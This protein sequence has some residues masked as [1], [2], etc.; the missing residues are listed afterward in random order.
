MLII[1]QT[2]HTVFYDVFKEGYLD[3]YKNVSDSV[4]AHYYVYEFSFCILLRLF[5]LFKD[6]MGFDAVVPFA[7]GTQLR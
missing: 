5:P 2:L 4:I 3:V 7:N 1:Q 6:S